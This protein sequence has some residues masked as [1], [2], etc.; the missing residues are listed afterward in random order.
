MPEAEVSDGGQE[1]ECAE[2][3]IGSDPD[4]GGI[5]FPDNGVLACGNENGA[6]HVIHDEGRGGFVVDGN[7]PAGVMEVSEDQRAAIG[8]IDFGAD[9]IGKVTLDRGGV[10]GAWM[11]PSE[12]LA[13]SLE[14]VQE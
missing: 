3:D 10:I 12:A 4:N 7:G 11:L 5:V 1:D 9:L 2:R 6:V 8:G 14:F 13:A